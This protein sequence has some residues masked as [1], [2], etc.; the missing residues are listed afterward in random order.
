MYALTPCAVIQ[1]PL[2][3]IKYNCFSQAILSPGLWV[4]HFAGILLGAE[5]QERDRLGPFGLW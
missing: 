5:W 4:T 3:S 2:L 1:F